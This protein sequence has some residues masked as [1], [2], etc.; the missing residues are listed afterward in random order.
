MPAPTE[1]ARRFFGA[2]LARRR[3]GEATDVKMSTQELRKMAS[4]AKR[5]SKRSKRNSRR[6]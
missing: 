5:S 4:K 2:E 3:R 6:R 1:R